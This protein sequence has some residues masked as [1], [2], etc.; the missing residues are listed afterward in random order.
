LSVLVGDRSFES[1]KN[2]SYLA[3]KGRLGRRSLFFRGGLIVLASMVFNTSLSLEELVFG[4]K[5]IGSV[6]WGLYD[7]S[8][9]LNAG[10]LNDGREFIEL[11]LGRLLSG[12]KLWFTRF[13][14][15]LMNWI[16]TKLINDY[17]F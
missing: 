7:F 5:R 1:D 6:G 9:F 11:L 16:G 2:F 8:I 12:A 13:L 17:G 3:G 15:F 4:L 10:R 14:A